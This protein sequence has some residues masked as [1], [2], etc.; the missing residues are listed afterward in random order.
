MQCSL[1]AVLWHSINVCHR[2]WKQWCAMLCN[3]IC[4]VSLLVAVLHLT[5]G[6]CVR[7]VFFTCR[8]NDLDLPRI[9]HTPHQHGHRQMSC[10]VIRILR[11][12]F[13]RLQHVAVMF[14][15]GSSPS[16]RTI[17]S[18]SIRVLRFFMFLHPGTSIP[19]S[20]SSFPAQVSPARLPRVPRLR[21]GA[22]SESLVLHSCCTQNICTSRCVALGLGPSLCEIARAHELPLP[23]L[24]FICSTCESFKSVLAHIPSTQLLVIALSSASGELNKMVASNLYTA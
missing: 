12:S 22:S 13:M 2:M 3:V 19:V 10:L 4:L 5:V 14:V 15:S 8:E 1:I 6:Q 9:C 20:H 23:G 7:V 16:K 11:I 24:Q 18:Q 17:I 21:H